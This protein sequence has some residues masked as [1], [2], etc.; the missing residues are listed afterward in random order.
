VTDYDS[1]LHKA[2][3]NLKTTQRSIPKVAGLKFKKAITQI[4][5][6]NLQHSLKARAFNKG[7]TFRSIV[8]AQ[9]YLQPTTQA[10][11]SHNKDL[12]P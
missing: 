5:P 8:H 2:D 10:T 9:G 3:L 12:S 1:N 11:S 7:K 6:L 4:K